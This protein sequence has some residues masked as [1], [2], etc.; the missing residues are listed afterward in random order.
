MLLLPDVRDWAFD[1]IARNVAP[2]LEGYHVSI[3]Y[4]ADVVAGQ[5]V[6]FADYDVVYAFHWLQMA[7]MGGRYYGHYDPRKVAASAGS[8]TI[9]PDASLEQVVDI[10]R[11]FGSF[12]VV[13]RRLAQ[14]YADASPFYTPAGVD[15]ELF[16]PRPLPSFDEG[17]TVLWVGNTDPHFHAH[18]KGLEEIVRPALAGL[19]KVRLL[20]ATRQSHL[21]HR[22]MPD[23]YARGHVFVCSSAS[24]G[25][26]LPLL[27]AMACGRPVVSTDVGVVPEL[28][29]ADCGRIIPR[30]AEALR[31][32][33]CELNESRESLAEMGRQAALRI[34]GR[35]WQAA[36]AALTRQLGATGLE[37]GLPQNLEPAPRSYYLHQPGPRECWLALA[38]GRPFAIRPRLVDLA[39]GGVDLHLGA[40]VLRESLG[41]AEM[42]LVPRLLWKERAVALG[43]RRVELEEHFEDLAPELARAPRRRRG[44][45]VALSLL[46]GCL[47]LIR[48]M[49]ARLRQ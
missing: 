18:N 34:R 27:E 44:V 48:T 41:H 31:K 25:G 15:L 49:L 42:V 33:I 11:E 9:P 10:L 5:K 28:V 1:I 14:R 26:P 46:K 29:D 21:A 39:T 24:E 20:V 19:P 22:A 47:D 43:A 13:S 37:A 8:E 32:A 6:D 7:R 30:C 38:S 2:H 16:R 3:R 36:A 23:F 4:V 17:L 40:R 45:R 12:G 35:T